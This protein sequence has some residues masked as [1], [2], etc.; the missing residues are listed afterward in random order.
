MGYHYAGFEV[1]GIDII[2]KY[3]R[4]YPFTFIQADA[5]EYATEHAHEYDVIHASPPCQAWSIATIGSGTQDRHPKLI[6]PIR[7]ILKASGRPY[8]IE[9]VIGAPLENTLTLC[10]T[11][12]GLQATDD[13]GTRLRLERHRLFES[14]VRITA[15][16]QCNHD[17]TI[18]VGGVYGGG[19]SNRWEAKYVRRGGYTPAKHV[20]EQLMGIDWMTLHGLSQSI[21]PAYSEWIGSQILDTLRGSALH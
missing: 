18:Q 10:G 12:F 7:E 20:R 8:V 6:E 14:N 5:I 4:R 17:K 3:A 9:N 15:P 21:P 19:R 11:M 1:T 16:R 13:D 2:G